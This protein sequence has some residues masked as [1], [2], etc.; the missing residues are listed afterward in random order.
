MLELE[1]DL[2]YSG[3]ESAFSPD[4]A[5]DRDDSPRSASRATCSRP[6][7]AA[8]GCPRSSTSTRCSARSR[9]S[10]TC[11]ASTRRAAARESERGARRVVPN[12]RGLTRPLVLVRVRTPRTSAPASARRSSC[13]TPS[14]SRTSRATSTTT[15]TLAQLGGGRRR[16][17]RRHRAHRRRL[18]HRRREDRRCSSRTRRP[19]SSTAVQAS[20]TSSLPFASSE[21]GVRTVDGRGIARAAARRARPAMTRVQPTRADRGRALLGDRARRSCS[22]RRSRSPSRS[23]PPTSASTRCGRAILATSGSAPTPLDRAARRHR[24]GAAAAPRADG[25]SGRCRPRDLRRGHAGDHPQPAGRPLPAR[26]VIRRLARRGRRAA[27]RRRPAAAARRV[28][29]RDRSRSLATLGARGRSAAHHPDAHRARRRRRLGA[30]RR[31]SRASSSSGPRPATPTARSS[32]GCSARSPVPLAGR[33]DRGHRACSSSGFRSCSRVALLDALRVRRHVRPRR[34]ASTCRRT[35]WGLLGGTALLTGAMVSV[36]GSIGFVGLV[37]PHAV[38]LL[39][40]PGHRALLPLSALVGAIFLIW[41]DTLARTVF[42]PREL[43]VGIVTAI[44]GAPV[45]ALLLARRRATRERGRPGWSVRDLTATIASG[46]PRGR[47]LDARRNS[48]RHRPHRSERRRQV[49]AA[50]SARRSAATRCG[51]A[52]VSSGDDLLALRRRER[53]RP[54]ALVEQETTTELSLRGSAVVGLG[55]IPAPVGARRT[56]SRLRPPST[57][58]LDL[59]GARAF[60]DREFATLSGGERQRVQ[61]ARALAQQPRAAAARRAD[62]PPR[63]RRAARRCWGCSGASRR[64]GTTVIAALH[65]L[66][67]AATTPIAS[68]CCRTDAS[69]RAGRPPRRSRRR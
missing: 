64:R 10:P 40:G 23:A 56:R 8:P 3:W 9:R 11:S 36:S 13:S 31:A 51:V 26:A 44:V 49:D 27:A 16:R 38:R 46:R 58:A 24:V 63:H 55:R 25:R 52:C 2:V 42:D 33:R 53:A 48:A 21:A 37:L 18:E 28:R 43:P 1:P 66:S 34:S 54:V 15:W 39:V 19:P 29:R 61:L 12:T 62:Q 6:R 14:G 22:S 65:D 68:S 30:R 7:A 60:A 59:A 45:F 57:A 67:L 5:G 20:A 69:S 32:A 17:P 41:A 35:R 47:R 4:A 50:A